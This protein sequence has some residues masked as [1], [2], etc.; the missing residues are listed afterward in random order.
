MIPSVDGMSIAPNRP[1]S[2]RAAMSIAGDTENAASTDA[3]PKPATPSMSSRRRP[4]LSASTPIVTS[5]AART[6]E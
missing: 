2:T 1:C 4:T 3:A 5:S 6:N